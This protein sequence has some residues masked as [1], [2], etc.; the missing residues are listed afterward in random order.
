MRA[1]ESRVPWFLSVL[2]VLLAVPFALLISQTSPSI[3]LLAAAAAI[4]LLIAFLSPLTGLFLL[5][6]S[7]LLGPE[8]L[9]GGTRDR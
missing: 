7:M 8:F 6:F 9:V 3:S 1:I 5:V 2:P 4:P